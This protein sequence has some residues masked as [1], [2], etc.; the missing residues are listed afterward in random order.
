MQ[1]RDFK[2]STRYSK[3]RGKSRGTRMLSQA[4]RRQANLSAKRGPVG[5]AAAAAAHSPGYHDVAAAGYGFHTTGTIK[6]LNDVP[7]G[8]ATDERIGK[9]VVLKSLQCRGSMD[10]GVDGTTADA[11]M[12][13]VYDKRPCGSLP[14]VTDVLNTINSTSFNNDDNSGR[15]RI[16]KRIDAMFIGGLNSGFTAKSGFEADWFLKLKGLPT[17]Y[18]SAGTGGIG[19]IE[20]GALYMITVGN[21]AN[22]TSSPNATVGFRL[23]Y[24]DV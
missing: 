15:F 12:L 18:K 23:R 21:K 9:K 10:A 8:A 7:Q 24:I 14:N 3:R 4:V 13:I 2:G 6:L 22:G 16:L 1:R 11:S 19:D 20:E 5:L 17:T